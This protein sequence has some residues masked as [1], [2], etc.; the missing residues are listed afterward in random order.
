MFLW[1][2]SIL[3]TFPFVLGKCSFLP[4]HNISREMRFEDNGKVVSKIVLR[5]ILY[6]LLNCVR[7][8]CGNTARGQGEKENRLK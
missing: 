7:Y 4:K 3:Y 6:M 1:K 2:A 8:E 5:S